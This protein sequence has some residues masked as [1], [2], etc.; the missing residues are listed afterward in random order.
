MLRKPFSFE[1]HDNER[2]QTI[3]LVAASMVALIAF[4]ALAI[5]VSTLYVARKEAQAAADAAALA[6]AKAFV[7]SGYTSG[8]M[9]QA[10]AQSLASQQATA[11]ALQARV[12][13]SPLQVWQASGK[14]LITVT[15]PGSTATN[16]RITVTVN[17]TS[18]PMF[19]S[20]VLWKATPPQVTTTASAEA[21]NPSGGPAPIQVAGVKPWLVPDCPPSTT[22]GPNP[23][24]STPY[25]VDPSSGAI[26]N[27]SLIGT[28]ISLAV[29][30]QPSFLTGP[31]SFP[32]YSFY[33]LN[34]PIN[35][36]AP[37]CGSCG[38]PTGNYPDNISCFN[39]QPIS[40]RQLL[41][42]D[43]GIGGPPGQLKTSTSLATRCLIHASSSNGPLT[44]CSAGLYQQDCFTPS[45]LGSGTPILISPGSNN[46]DPALSRATNISRSESVVTVPLYDGRNLCNG[47][48]CTSA[49]IL[50]FLQLG[51]TRDEGNGVIEA[52]IL[53][54]SGCNSG[55]TA[56]A[57]V[58]GGDISP[59]PVRLVQ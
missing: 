34:V 16:P 11:T 13:G 3:A 15:F 31:P 58:S 56:T 4:F 17:V 30:D 49:T 26:V 43:P 32:I 39:P 42:L 20:R 7:S 5:D 40:C 38:G 50:G 46:P 18:L 2:G 29:Q 47:G 12:A 54:A 6:G 51:I 52:M 53:N 23:N 45:A 19:F 10:N 25:F 8:F 55:A 37:S 41:S 14:A 44:G 27:S 48:V 21:Y 36:P 35:P 22:A 24:C 9:P 57:A 1:I 33:P 28:T 59:I